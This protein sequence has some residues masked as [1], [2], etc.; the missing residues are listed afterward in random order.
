MAGRRKIV[1][2]GQEVWGEDVEFETDHEAWNT[3]VLHDGTT[4]KMKAVVSEVVRL[5][6]YN[7]GGDPVYLIKSTNVVTAIVPE[8]LKKKD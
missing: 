1:Y 3:Y 6:V 7:P 2:Q 8:N 5:D 4:L